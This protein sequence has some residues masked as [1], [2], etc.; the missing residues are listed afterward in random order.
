MTEDRKLHRRPAGGRPPKQ[1]AEEAGTRILETA[2]HLFAS[3]G[4]AGTSVEQVAS[5]CGA[6]KDTIY[7]RFPS[8]VALFEAV[9]EHVRDRALDRLN[10]LAPVDG[11]A[12]KQLKALLRA[13][14][15]INMEPDLVALKRIAF[16]EAVVFAKSSAAS[17][18]SD[19]FMER[20]VEAVR[21]AQSDGFLRTGD[22]PSMASHLIHSLVSLPTTNAM[23]G[24]SDYDSPEALDAHFAVIWLWMTEGVIAR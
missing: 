4:F 18:G 23:L 11:D 9:V 16:S 5:A 24:G 12:L 6:G 21:A 15:S 2:T 13:Y 17:S 3:R 10:G 14:L 7:R 8:K 22:A 1:R 19:P 20:L